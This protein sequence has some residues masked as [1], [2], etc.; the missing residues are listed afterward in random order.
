MART[1]DDNLFRKEKN[2]KHEKSLSK[3]NR[4]VRKEVILHR[5]IKLKAFDKIM[6][7]I[8]NRFG[9]LCSCIRSSRKEKL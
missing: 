3:M 6:L 8:V 4:D 9:I 5:E 1:L 7:Y 2:D